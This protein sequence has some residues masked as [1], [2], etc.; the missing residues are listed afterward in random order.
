MRLV[1]EGGESGP[2]IVAGKPQESPLLQRLR[3]GEMPPGD[4]P[5]PPALIAI[6]EKCLAG[7]AATIR[8]EPETL[9]PGL[10]ITPEERSFWS[11]Q[12]IQRPQL[13]PSDQFPQEAR[14]R[15][16]LD[17]LVWTSPGFGP[18]ADRRTLILLASFTLIGLPPTAEQLQILLASP[19]SRW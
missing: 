18:D 16:D 8:P 11:F 17:A 9:P 10:G 7:G 14:I 6:L 1:K 5:I 15:T 2:A 19:S 4:H 3:N 12:P 13:P